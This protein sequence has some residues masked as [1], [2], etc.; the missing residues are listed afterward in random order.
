[1]SLLKY[2]AFHFIPDVSHLDIV[3]HTLSP[4]WGVNLSLIILDGPWEDSSLIL[5]SGYICA[6]TSPCSWLPFSSCLLKTHW[7]LDLS[8]ADSIPRYILECS[9]PPSLFTLCHSTFP[10]SSSYLSIYDQQGMVINT[11][12]EYM[13]VSLAFNRG[14]MG[15][16]QFAKVV[17]SK[18]MLIKPERAGRHY[19]SPA[20]R[21][22]LLDTIFITMWSCICLRGPSSSWGWIV[23]LFSRPHCLLPQ[24][25]LQPDSPTSSPIW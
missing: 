20:V 8:D 16:L 9:L 22:R 21:S 6:I 25:F 14:N 1:M 13:Y 15:T 24:S 10:F 17:Y 3:S 7:F 4:F 11:W 12:T 2:L 19:L 5:G 23:L 18:S